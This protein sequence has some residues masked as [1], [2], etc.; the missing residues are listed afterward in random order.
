MSS[1]NNRYDDEFKASAVKMVVEKRRP[2]S[3]VAK[4][5]GVSE[6]ALRRW[7]KANTEHEDAVSKK[8][9]ELEAENKKLKKELDDAKDTVEVLK[10]SVAIFIKP[11]K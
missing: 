2:I 10:K 7:V 8:L 9:V 3:A 4:D 11:Q 1:N 5:L 6:P